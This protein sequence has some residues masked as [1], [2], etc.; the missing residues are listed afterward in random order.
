MARNPLEQAEGHFDRDQRWN[1]LAVGAHGGLAAPL[2]NGFDGLFIKAEARAL[3]HRNVGHTA[4]ERN[5]TLQH[6][7]ALVLGFAGFV[8]IL[9][10]RRVEA[11]RH[12]HAVD[13]GAEQATARAAAFTG[14]EAAAG[15]AAD[16]GSVAMAERI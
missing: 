13:A 11:G 4:I 3:K 10:I 16:A 14:A 2:A 7:N 9:R 1:G 8:G 5:H 12:A 6:N 15:T